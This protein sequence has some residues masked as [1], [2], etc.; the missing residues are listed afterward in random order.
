MNW[1]VPTG[2][3]IMHPAHI[4]HPHNAPSSRCFCRIRLCTAA[5]GWGSRRSRFL[6]TISLQNGAWRRER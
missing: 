5:I 2:D 3:G 4:G 6:P 1:S